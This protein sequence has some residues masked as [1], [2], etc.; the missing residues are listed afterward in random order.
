MRKILTTVLL[1]VLA[2]T[3][4]AAQV[5]TE[6]HASVIAW[7]WSNIVLNDRGQAAFSS[8]HGLPMLWQRGV[9]AIQLPGDVKDSRIAGINNDGI[10]VGSALYANN[11]RYLYYQPVAW[12]G[13][14]M[15]RLTSLGDRGA[16]KGINSAGTTIG[17]VEGSD[18]FQAFIQ[19]DGVDIALDGF[20][21]AD[22]NDAGDVVGMHHSELAL[23]HDGQFSEVPDSSD[24][25]PVAIN[26][27]GWVAGT[28]YWGQSVLWKDGAAL[29][30]GYGNA[31]DLNDD[32]MVVGTTAQQDHA[33][34]WFDGKAYVLDHLWREAQWAGWTLS[35]ALAINN[36]GQIAVWAQNTQTT[37]LAMLLLIPG[38]VPEPAPAALL[39]AGLALVGARRLRSGR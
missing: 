24:A 23:W 36:Q 11:P 27:K 38:P 31:L 10:V 28:R 1:T 14:A 32:G 8:E 35:S 2:A 7:N 18:G 25:W 13:G 39:L 33:L 34:L 9:G 5:P 20:A 19:R 30:L 3:P 4:A 16:A 15:E 37:Q 29:T 22:I 17:E 6:Y 21:P 26:G 12:R